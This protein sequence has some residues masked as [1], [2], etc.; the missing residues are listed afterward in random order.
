M[1]YLEC[2]KRFFVLAF[3]TWNELSVL[4]G[5]WKSIFIEGK[6]EENKWVVIFSGFLRD[7][8]STIFALKVF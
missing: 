8:Y 5:Y 6:C 1:G 2:I 3:Y 4:T 7:S